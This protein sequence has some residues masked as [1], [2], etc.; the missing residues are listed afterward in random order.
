ME[1]RIK[2][3]IEEADLVASGSELLQQVSANFSSYKETVENFTDPDVSVMRDKATGSPPKQCQLCGHWITAK[4]V[5]A[6]VATHL[7]I[8]RLRC[9]SCGQGFDRMNRASI[10]IDKSHPGDPKAKIE[11]AM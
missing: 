9:T 2:E 4:N 7:T 8:R 10:H 1:V 5:R 6:H 11:S 3:E